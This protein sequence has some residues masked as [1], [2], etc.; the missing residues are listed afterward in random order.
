MQ[1]GNPGKDGLQEG[2]E[3]GEKEQQGKE[4]ESDSQDKA[5][6]RVRLR[7]NDLRSHQDTRV[8]EEQH[9]S[10]LLIIVYASTW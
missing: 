7:L 2:K 9:Q 3:G 8:Q 1:S 10:P 4:D 6:D 5:Q